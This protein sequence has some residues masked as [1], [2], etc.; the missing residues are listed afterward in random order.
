MKRLHPPQGGE[1]PP[2]VAT[3]PDG[4]VVALRPLAERVTAAYF[5]EFS[6]DRDRPRRRRGCAGT[7]APWS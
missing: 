4:T 1:P 3:L 2:E 7:G 5:D 6:D